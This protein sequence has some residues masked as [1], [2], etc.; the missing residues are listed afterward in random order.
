[1]VVG[2]EPPRYE[3]WSE[4]GEPARRL[5]DWL[6]DNS[7]CIT[8]AV[9]LGQI[10]TLIECPYSMTHSA[11]SADA[12]RLRHLDPSGCRLSVGLEDWHDLVADLEEGLRQV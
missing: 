7:Y 3:T 11:M 2:V 6:A 1:M 5:V 8:L 4:S 10:K 12:K 9:S